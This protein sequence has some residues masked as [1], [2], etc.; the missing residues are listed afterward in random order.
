M[1]PHQTYMPDMPQNICSQRDTW[2][3][4]APFMNLDQIYFYD[5][6]KTSFAPSIVKFSDTLDI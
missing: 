5:N 6:A 2:G 3:S 1:G 4:T